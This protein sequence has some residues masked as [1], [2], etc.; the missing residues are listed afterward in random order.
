MI[1]LKALGSIALI[2]LIATLSVHYLTGQTLSEY[3][4]KNPEL[5]Y[6]TSEPDS[7]EITPSIE[8]IPAEE[9]KVP[10]NAS[11]SV[12]AKVP[13]NIS[14]NNA[15]NINI[16]NMI[17]FYDVNVVDDNYTPSAERT[18]YEK[19][20][21]YEP[22]SDT[23]TNYITGISYP[24]DNVSCEV[25]YEE[26]RYVGI[27]Y[28]DF[29]GLTQAGELICNESIAEDLVEIFC[30]LYHSDYRLEKVVLVDNYNGD[31][32]ASMAADNTSC[33]N[34]R[35]VAN[36]TS[37]SNHAYGK[38]IDINPFYN[39]YIVFGG[40][41]D[42]TDYISPS[43]SEPYVDRSTSFAYKIDENDLCYKL[44]KQHGFSWGGDWNH[45]KDYQH[46]Q[47]K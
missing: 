41:P 5:A 2:I 9:E 18:L 12:S 26:L 1:I 40:N 45:S 24:S 11:E 27:L 22:L 17:H 31:D 39:P 6:G 4:E 37:L 43:G 30:E 20:F 15:L 34:Y 42:G 47:K 10:E 36:T 13:E 35:E 44:F 38:A 33:F 14:M 23:V 3:A 25:S 8:E 32:T 28:I 7:K 46:F 16:S 29:N 21:Y 19:G